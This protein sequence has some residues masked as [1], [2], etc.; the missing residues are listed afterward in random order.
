MDCFSCMCSLCQPFPSLLIRSFKCSHFYELSCWNQPD[1]VICY[2]GNAK[3][4]LFELGPINQLEIFFFCHY[5]FLLLMC[6]KLH[7]LICNKVHVG[8]LPPLSTCWHCVSRVDEWKLMGCSMTQLVLVVSRMCVFSPLCFHVCLSFCM[9][10]H[11]FRISGNPDWL[12]CC[13]LA[14]QV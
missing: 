6:I 8:T 5:L 13:C 1:D 12:F 7:C 10:Y 14:N 11:C 4:L 2:H 9:I 3:T